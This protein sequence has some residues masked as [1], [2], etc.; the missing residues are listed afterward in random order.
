ML[1]QPLRLSITARP[2]LRVVRRRKYRVGSSSHPIDPLMSIHVEEAASLFELHAA[3]QSRASV[4]L[5]DL[6]RL[7]ERL[8]GHVDGVL[9]A[10]ES[11]WRQCE[12][13][14]AQTSAGAAQVSA[15]W[16]L[17]AA[18]VNRLNELCA[19]AASE[20][21]VR[22]ELGRALSWVDKGRLRGIVAG[23]LKSDDDA[24]RVLGLDA[25]A[26]HYVDP[27]AVLASW[28]VDS[29]PVVR[30]RALRAAGELGRVDLLQSCVAAIED[31]DD[32][33]RAWAAWSAVLLGDR[34]R[35]LRALLDV[36]HVPGPHQ[37]RAFALALQAMS[38]KAGAA[39]LGELIKD[40]SNLRRVIQGSG[41]VGD[42]AHI[43]WLITQMKDVATAR[44]AGEA[45]ALIVGADLSRQLEAERPDGFQGG[46]SD[47]PEDE[48]VALDP[49]ESLPWPDVQGIERRWAVHASHFTQG[50]RYF[51]GAPVTRAHCVSV[52]G[53]GYQR[54][55]LLAAHHLC[56]ME[57]GTQL[58]NTSAPAWRQRRWLG[59]MG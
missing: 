8:A 29:S 35:G 55:R 17:H 48:D 5:L 14:L 54:Q 43:P 52:L 51:V 34:N 19:R 10:G 20:P 7:H 25:C 42:P 37:D 27:G 40:Q 18:D 12:A 44:L 28:V 16:A 13:A 2:R 39:A 46:P 21:R 56:L 1:M 41:I 15:I 30:A 57:P 32:N 26:A 53:Q 6:D 49:D 9:T 23:F 33:C 59:K 22:E 24:R 45:F 58:F 36:A 3:L 50:Q 11:G 31:P 4:S 38:V 47:R